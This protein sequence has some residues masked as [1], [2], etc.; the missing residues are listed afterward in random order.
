MTNILHD[1]PV[2]EAIWSED[3]GGCYAVE[4]PIADIWR[5]IGSDN[6]N[7]ELATREPNTDTSVHIQDLWISVP[8]L[9]NNKPL[10][11][12]AFRAGTVFTNLDP[13]IPSEQY[14]SAICGIGGF[15]PDQT[16]NRT[17][18]ASAAE[19][20]ETVR[21]PMAFAFTLLPIQN[22]C[23]FPEQHKWLSEKTARMLAV[24]CN[25]WNHP[26]AIDLDSEQ[27]PI[28]V[29]LRELETAV[30]ETDACVLPN[31]PYHTDSKITYLEAVVS[32]YFASGELFEGPD[33][34]IEIED[35]VNLLLKFRTYVE[36]DFQACYDNSESEV[37]RD[38]WGY[39]GETK[40]RW[41]ALSMTAKMLVNL[42]QCQKVPETFSA[43]LH[44]PSGTCY[45]V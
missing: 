43:L 28:K 36:Q 11:H 32:Q 19:H 33:D 42:C 37:I 35:A 14:V 31:L 44:S 12:F 3:F 6:P 30:T 7:S 41:V 40:A 20:W 1:V 21:Q 8:G 24:A 13:F 18:F 27:V 39:F 4:M 16:C 23:Y 34:F 2:Y 26:D 38:W 22:R 5:I 29:R 17:V 9:L 25:L 10:V 15:P 45:I